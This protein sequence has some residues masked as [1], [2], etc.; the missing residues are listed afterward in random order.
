MAETEWS[1]FINE[2]KSLPKSKG[3]FRE[4][5]SGNKDSEKDSSKKGKLVIN[6]PKAISDFEKAMHKFP[7]KKILYKTIFRGKGLEFDSYRVFAPDDNADLID[8]KASL[9]SNDIMVKKY[10][11]ERELNIYFLVDVSSSMLFGSSNKLKSEFAAEFVAS[12]SHLVVGSGDRIGLVMFN[13]DVVKV[14][15]PSSSKN[16]FALF[17]KFLSDG[18]LY[19]GGFNLDSAIEYS[20][21]TAKSPY[22]V[23]IVVSD[24]IKTTKS[25]L[26]NLK[27]MGSKFET[28][29]VM[30]RDKMDNELPKTNY[31]FSVQDPYSGRQMILDPEIAAERYRYNVLR[32]KAVVKD[33][34]RA[35][36]IDFLELVTDK[37]LAIPLSIFLKGRARGSRI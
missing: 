31:Q 6:F 33:M 27:L 11:E 37:S 25:N 32:Q 23:F 21:R 9:R 36:R 12:L 20:L 34:L 26:R 5:F 13:E 8:W 28:L 4:L 14:L 10:I 24:F 19:G 2:G 29:A 3:F 16:Q 22:T 30:I 1:K 7:V 35:S 15:P 17:T 18:S